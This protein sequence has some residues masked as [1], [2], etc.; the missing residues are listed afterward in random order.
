MRHRC[1]TG[2]ADFGPISSRG[3]NPSNIL[4]YYGSKPI[5]ICVIC[6]KI[7]VGHPFVILFSFVRLQVVVLRAL[8]STSTLL[9]L[10]PLDSRYRVIATNESIDADLP[11]YIRSVGGLHTCRPVG[12]LLKKNEAINCP[13]TIYINF[14]TT[15]SISMISVRAPPDMGRVVT[16]S[17]GSQTALSRYWTAT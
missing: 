1:H 5:I 10:L 4:P 14:R 12:P 11:I 13:D 3:S 8:R 9:C 2:T 7:R 16:V 17:L 6:K 15:I